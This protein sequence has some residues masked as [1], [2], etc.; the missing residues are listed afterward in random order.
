[1]PKAVL[2]TKV[3]PSYDDL[4]EHRYHFKRR[5]LRAAKAALGDWIV[6]Y[7]PRRSSADLSS[8]G[9]RQS[10][11]ATAR[12]AH[13]GRDPNRDDHYYAYV[14]DYLEFDRAV[15]SA[16]GTSTTRAGCRRRT[17][18]RTGAGSACRCGIWRI[19]NT[20]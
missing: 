19:P 18:R 14:E 1:M 11:F 2:T 20:A 7:E 13:I 8:S 9:G 17:V 12:I 3:D 6:Y 4:P 5:H 16:R 10:Y 15:P